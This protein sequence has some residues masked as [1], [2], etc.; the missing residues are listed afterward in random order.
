MHRFDNMNINSTSMRT[1]SVILALVTLL[2][3]CEKSSDTKSHGYTARI[4]GYDLNCSTCILS[5]PFDS[6]TVK[7]DLGSSPENLYQAVNLNK[8]DLKIGQ[9]LKVEVRKAG[10]EE[11]TACLAQYPSP[12]YENVFVTRIEDFDTLGSND[13][14]MLPIKECRFNTE[15]Q[16][17]ICFE[18][19]VND[20]RCPE[21][22]ECFWA[23]DAKV[24]FKYIRLNEDPLFFDLNTNTSFTNDS[25]IDGYRY[26]LLNLFP[27]PSLMHHTD[28][29]DYRAELF[30]EKVIR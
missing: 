12:S 28:Q 4:A 16:T 20:S 14:I 24:K 21:G 1:L 8:N 13:T 10:P 5:F 7:N 30:I 27:Y 23:G 26:T 22:A 17:Y 11:L 19:V 18:S 15:N 2:F 3:S 9:M 6:N 29:K 25:I